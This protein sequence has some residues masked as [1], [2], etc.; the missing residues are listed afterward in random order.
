M[1]CCS[2]AVLSTNWNPA[3]DVSKRTQSTRDSA[4]TTRLVHSAAQRALEATV[5]SSP[6]R[7][8]ITRPPSSGSQVINDRMGKPAA[9]M[10]SPEHQREAD[11]CNDPDQ[12]R[13]GIDR[14][15][16]G[17][18]AHHLGGA[19]GG[20]RRQFVGNPVDDL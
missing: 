2:Q 19:G 3:S 14:D 5:A 10:V 12:H 20:Q 6:P 9:F 11:Q 8:M 16:T 17:L 15:R 7:D 13:E 4:N 18:Q 1:P